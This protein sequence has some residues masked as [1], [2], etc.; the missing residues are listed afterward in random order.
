MLRLPV[1]RHHVAPSG[2]ISSGAG[3]KFQKEIQSGDGKINT[4]GDL[5]N[6]LCADLMIMN[7][8]QKHDWGSNICFDHSHDW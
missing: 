3:S 5:V 1:S 8:A 6:G 7:N 4:L 2:G